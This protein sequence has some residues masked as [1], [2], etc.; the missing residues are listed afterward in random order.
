MRN[1]TF[2]VGT[3][4]KIRD[5][6][7]VKRIRPKKDENTVIEKRIYRPVCEGNNS[8]KQKHVMREIQGK[9]KGHP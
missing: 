8:L 1:P 7:L 2:S 6:V 5:T 3:V 9:K 4:W